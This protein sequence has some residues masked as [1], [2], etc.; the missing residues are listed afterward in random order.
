MSWCVSKRSVCAYTHVIVPAALWQPSRMYLRVSENYGYTWGRAVDVSLAS[1]ST[2]HA[3]CP[4]HAKVV[5][6]ICVP[7]LCYATS[8][9]RALRV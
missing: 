6:M 3:V 4:S 7:L 2:H 8:L 1:D 5:P 9:R